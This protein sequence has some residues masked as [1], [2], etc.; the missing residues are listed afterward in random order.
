MGGN[1]KPVWYVIS[2]NSFQ[3]LITKNYGSKKKKCIW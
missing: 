1:P 3:Y 2:D